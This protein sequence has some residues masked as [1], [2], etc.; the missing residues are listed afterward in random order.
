MRQIA[1]DMM[2]LLVVG[3]TLTGCNH[4][5]GVEDDSRPKA[6]QTEGASEQ[7]KDGGGSG[8]Y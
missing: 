4:S 2:L 8:G 5:G 3:S 6:E 7:P 1:F